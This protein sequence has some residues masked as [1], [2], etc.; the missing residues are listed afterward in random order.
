MSQRPGEPERTLNATFT[1]HSAP[2]VNPCDMRLK[3]FA[4]FVAAVA[5]VLVVLLALSQRGGGGLS[6]WLRHI[7]GH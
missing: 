5:I 4:W 2:M 7:P 1:D 3:T 6:T